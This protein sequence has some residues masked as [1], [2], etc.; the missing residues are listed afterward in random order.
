MMRRRLFAIV[1][2]LFAAGVARA[3]SGAFDAEQFHPSDTSN[4][5]FG[6]DGAFVARHL[7]L[8]AGA[9]LTYGHDP[10]VLRR[11]GA[12]VYPGGEVITRQLGLDLVGSFALL[13]RLELGF[14]LPFIPYE[15]ADN[16]LAKL[17]DFHSSGLGDL[18]L[19]VKG[20]LWAPRLGVHRFGLSV[21]AGITF[22]TG[23]SGSFMGE[24]SVTGR[25]RLVGEW[26]SP[27]L[28][29]AVNLGFVLRPER[30]FADLHVTHQLEYGVAVSTPPLPHGFAVLGE[31]RGLVGIDLPSG[32]SL[33]S[34]EAPAEL[35]VGLRW[36]TRFGLA[37]EAAIGAGL[38]RGY[39]VP[40]RARGIFGIRYTTPDRP[41]PSRPAV[42][43]PPPPPPDGDHD[44][45][46]DD[47][48][49]CPTDPG[50]RANGGC[51]DTDSDGDGVPDRLDKCVLDK[52]PAALGGCPAP[53]RDKDGVPDTDDRCP[54]KAG[55]AQ[56]QGCP[57]FDSDGDGYVDRL[58]KC[59]FDPETFNGVDDDDG[60]P[61]QPSALATL[62]GDK[63]VIF[64]PVLFEKDGSVVD[65]RSYKLLSVVAHILKLHQ[66]ILK[67]R[68]EG[69][70]DNRGPA[71]QLLD[72]SRARAASVRRW[73]V[74]DGGIDPKRLVAE[75][76]GAD[77]P[78]ADNRDFIGR[79]KNRRIEFVIMQ[80]LDTGP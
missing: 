22:P 50:P 48:D 42:A 28:W 41:R 16:T 35:A 24:G 40:D 80:R 38:S 71:L 53:D 17:P 55:V 3:Q 21:V 49:H 58:D 33:T 69:H 13:D 37:L 74:H 19:D 5:Y 29:A 18:R 65:K 59:P 39:G 46:P 4:G 32:A 2:V 6:V 78:I 23:D 15:L 10:L 12:I 44:G 77:R 20:L 45:V 14:D 57:D 75:G 52:G 8:S 47:D 27:W 9:Y 36:R 34:A 63:I 25:P 7:G 1:A 66:E 72:L 60:C 68:I 73:L 31:V 26:R 62:V 30:D 54:D 79:A 11:D 61:D 70:M 56:N 76:F 51:P 64:E 67:L 43:P